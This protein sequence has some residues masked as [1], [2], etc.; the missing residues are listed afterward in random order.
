[1]IAVLAKRIGASADYWRSHQAEACLAPINEGT[2]P[3]EIPL[4]ASFQISRDSRPVVLAYHRIHANACPGARAIS[5]DS[6][7]AA[8]AEETRTS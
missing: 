7:S 3:H 5:T 8:N 6:S 4:L 1:M 2:K